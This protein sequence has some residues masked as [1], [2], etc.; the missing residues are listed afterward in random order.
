MRNDIPILELPGSHGA[1]IESVIAGRTLIQA[2]V[3]PVE[4][5][6]AEPGSCLANAA[7]F[8]L[9]RGGKVWVGRHRAVDLGRSC[10][11]AWVRMPD[12]THLDPTPMT[13]WG[14]AVYLGIGLPS[15]V[16]LPFF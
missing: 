4:F 6:P 10:H 2:R 14:R 3:Q 1:W 8:V 15:T 13:M 5:P 9:V 7:A 12:G 11:H 16:S